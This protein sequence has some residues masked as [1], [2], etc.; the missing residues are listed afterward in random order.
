LYRQFG[1]LVV[2]VLWLSDCTGTM[3]VHL[4]RQCGS[5]VVPV[6]WLSDC[7]GNIAVQLY[8]KYGFP[9]VHVLWLSSGTGII[10]GYRQMTQVVP[11]PLV[12]STQA[13]NKSSTVSHIYLLWPSNVVLASVLLCT[14]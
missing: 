2:P 8:R 1:S 5:L 10:V 7:T 4:Y 14:T 6:L 9:V 11:E 12:R 3:A 13:V